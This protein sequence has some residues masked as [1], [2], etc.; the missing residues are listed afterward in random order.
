[1]SDVGAGHAHIMH[2]SH[3]KRRKIMGLDMAS[4]H[5]PP[6]KDREVGRS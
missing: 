6:W 5:E 4:L 3:E 1:M 2:G